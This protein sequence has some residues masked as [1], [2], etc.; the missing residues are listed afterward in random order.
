M[1]QSLG[2]LDVGRGG[3]GSGL[4]LPP[5]ALGPSSLFPQVLS[6]LLCAVRTAQLSTGAGPPSL[7]L[8]PG[9]PPRT[10]DTSQLSFV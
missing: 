10:L 7:C 6:L 5:G 8:L 9:S 1:A 4:E 3:L 2:F